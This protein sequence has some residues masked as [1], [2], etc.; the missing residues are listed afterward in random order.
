MTRAVV[1]VAS[2]FPTDPVRSVS[3]RRGS[4]RSAATSSA[5]T[6]SSEA[7]T[8]PSTSSRSLLRTL[9]LV[10]LLMVREIEQV[11]GASVEKF[12]FVEHFPDPRLDAVESAATALR[13]RAPSSDLQQTL[14]EHTRREFLADWTRDLVGER[15]VAEPRRRCDLPPTAG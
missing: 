5:S 1:L 13:S 11:D 8:S 7:T 3:S 15:H 4:V 14:L 10:D 12:A 9:D 2:G 6:C